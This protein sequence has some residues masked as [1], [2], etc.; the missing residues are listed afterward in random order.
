MNFNGLSNRSIN[1]EPTERVVIEKDVIVDLWITGDRFHWSLSRVN[2]QS[3]RGY[4]TLRPENMKEVVLAIKAIA[5]VFSNAPGLSVGLQSYC[6]ALSE[7]LAGVSDRLE[8]VG[9]EKENGHGKSH[10]LTA[11]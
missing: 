10:F 8:G 5:G 6:Q 11:R 9:D 2:P 3:E 1:R 7:E 4:R